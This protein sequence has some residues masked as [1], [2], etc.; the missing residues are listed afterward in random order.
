MVLP[1]PLPDDDTVAVEPEPVISTA[2]L[3]VTV[4]V[5]GGKSLDV[6]ADTLN[7]YLT[8]IPDPAWENW[9]SGVY[10]VYGD[11]VIIPI[12]ERLASEAG[13]DSVSHVERIVVV[14]QGSASRFS[15]WLSSLD[16]ASSAGTAVIVETTSSVAAGAS[17][18]RNYPVFINGDRE[19]H[20]MYSCFRGESL[21][22]IPALED[23]AA[24]RI[25]VIPEM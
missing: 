11:S 17:W 24:Y 23:D 5:A 20:A 1:L 4:L 3:P 8:G 13:F 6:S 19:M 7:Q 18:I 15:S 22:G 10:A 25:L 12:A 2:H 21:P 9:T 16:P 14:R